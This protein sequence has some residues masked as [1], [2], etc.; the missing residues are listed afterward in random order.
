[1][2]LRM[3]NYKSVR[4]A[5]IE[6]SG[7]T[8]LYSQSASGK[9]TIFEALKSLLA[10]KFNEASFTHG[11]THL[12]IEAEFNGDKVKI[13]RDSQT[14][15]SSLSFNDEPPL[16][17]LG[18]NH[19]HQLCKF[20]IRDIIFPTEIFYPNVASQFKIP[21]FDT[22]SV[23]D[24]FSSMFTSIAQ[25][26]EAVTD[27]KAKVAENRSELNAATKT[28]EILESQETDMSTQLTKYKNENPDIDKKIIQ[29]NQAKLAEINFKAYKMSLLR[30]TRLNSI[31]FLKMQL[32]LV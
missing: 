15:E 7:L 5:D 2:H 20:P 31:F 10:N 23:Y 19:L 6:I 22:I 4:E 18:R 14:G 17:K 8:F 3:K 9:S 24:L 12:E 27:T 16:T 28:L 25:L 32:L 21:V 30:W 13:V 1:M 26:S 11:E 29:L